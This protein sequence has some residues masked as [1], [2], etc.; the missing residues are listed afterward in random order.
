MSN[1]FKEV[2]A[3]ERIIVALDCDFDRACQ[4]ADILSGKA[5]WVKVGMTLYYAAGPSVVAMLKEHGFKVFLDLKFH[6]IPH[7][8]EG[9]AYAAAESG[10]DMLTAHAIGGPDMMRAA[11]QGAEAGAA[12]IGTDMPSLLG[13]TVLTSIDADTLALTGVSR[14][15]QEQVLSL[16]QLACTAGATGVVASP[17]E[18]SALRDA[19]GSEALIVTPGVR[20]RHSAHD[21]QSRVAAPAQAFSNGASH[22][23]IGRPII[24]ADDPMAAF[25]EIAAEILL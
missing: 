12:D 18:A 6:D 9:A 13:I 19:L 11:L 8:V 21:D 3:S 4:L 20:P 24:Q 10:A 15:L 23:V 14:P 16:A 22:I 2:P 5:S 1:S 7:Q 25:D 17:Q